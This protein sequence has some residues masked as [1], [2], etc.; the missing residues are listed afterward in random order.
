MSKTTKVNG[1]TRRDVLRTLGGCAAMSQTAMLSTLLNLKLTRAA[2]AAHHYTDYKA[3]VCLFLHGGI[4]SYNV[5]VPVGESITDTIK[6]PYNDYLLARSTL[7]LSE[8][9]LLPITDPTDGRTYGLH[10]GLTELKQLYDFGHLAFVA[11]VGSLIE[12][13]SDV[14]AYNAARRPLGLFSHNDQ[15]RHWQTA[16]PQSRTQITGWLG[17]MADV[18]DDLGNHN[19]VIPMNIA[20]DHLNILQTGDDI[21]PYVVDDRYGAEVLAGYG[22]GNAAN[23]ILTQATDS[24]LDQS[25]SDLLKR[26]FADTNRQAI[27]AA[28]SYNEE[29][30]AVNLP[31]SITGVLDDSYIGRQLW[32]VARAIGARGALG[33]D[34]QTFFVE[35]G[36]WDHHTGLLGAQGNMLPELSAALKA[37]YEALEFLEVENDVLTF[38]VSDFARTLGANTNVGS[39]HAW[40][41]NHIVMGGSVD[42]GKIYGSYPDLY[43]GNSLDLGRGRLIPTTAVDE[44]AAQIAMWFG[45]DNDNVLETVLPNIR[46][47]YSSS[48]TT[49]PLGFML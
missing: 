34:R 5:L 17:R 27:D 14:S 7:A 19:A 33:Q 21:V 2:V 26:T 24:F 31:L 9:S 32:Q 43:P 38:S 12:P 23:T 1:P 6:Q 45:L 3:L 11:N 30:S 47:F 20:I 25:Y 8:P 35:R 28:V 13:I 4:D 37:F 36:G 42:G 10:P 22:G 40:G 44:Y 39:D 48:E 49:P 29:T 18:L 15:Q 41:A 46:T 16:T